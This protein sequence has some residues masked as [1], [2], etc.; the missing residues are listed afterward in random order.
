[1]NRIY[2]YIRRSVYRVTGEVTEEGFR[3]LFAFFSYIVLKL[4]RVS[5]T[6]KDNVLVVNFI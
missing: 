3:F 5:V 1:M 6:L 2:L 4:L